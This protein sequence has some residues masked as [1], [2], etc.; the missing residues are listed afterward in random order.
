MHQLD[1]TAVM[2]INTGICAQGNENQ[3]EGKMRIEKGDNRTGS[4][5]LDC[6]NEPKST[7]SSVVWRQSTGVVYVKWVIHLENLFLGQY[8]PA[9]I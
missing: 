1:N 8:C 6:C 2:K 5:R 4:H 9:E 3:M 7:G